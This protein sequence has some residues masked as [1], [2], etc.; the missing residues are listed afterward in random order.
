MKFKLGYAVKSAEPNADGVT[1]TIEKAGGS[2]PETMEAD[3][4]LVAI[5]RRPHT[6]VPFQ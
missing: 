1:I 2:E 5:G 6:E 3:V 4:V